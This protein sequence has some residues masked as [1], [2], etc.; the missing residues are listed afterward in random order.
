MTRILWRA[1]EP[2]LFNQAHDLMSGVMTDRVYEDTIRSYDFSRRIADDEVHD[3]AGRILP[4]GSTRGAKASPIV[5]FNALGWPRTD[6]AT[7]DVGFTDSDV[8][9]RAA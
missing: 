2:M 7:A 4:R 9:G 8:D 3:R 5:V 1:W 6:I